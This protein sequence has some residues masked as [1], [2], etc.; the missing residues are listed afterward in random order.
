MAD[1]EEKIAPRRR[2][3][4]FGGL[5]VILVLL[6]GISWL[7]LRG[8]LNWHKQTVGT[9]GKKGYGQIRPAYII[10]PDGT[11]ENRLKGKVCV[12]HIF[13]ENP[14]LTPANKTILDVGQRLYDQ[15]AKGDMR[16]ADAFRLAMVAEGGTAEF[17]SHAQKLPSADYATWVWAGGIG[18]WRTVVEN[19][20]EYFLKDEGKE[21]DKDYFALTDTTGTIRRFYNALDEQQINR[22]AEHISL[23]LPK[24]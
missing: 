16:R 10:Y 17:R 24:E 21:P 4:V 3:I 13:G 11:K 18:G 1:S 2:L 22:M 9:L 6:P 5:F 23:L 20:Y 15:F 14:D 8:G 12:V 7:V 19:G